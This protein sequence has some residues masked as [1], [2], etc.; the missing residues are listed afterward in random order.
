MIEE[1]TPS[2]YNTAS[3]DGNRGEYEHPARNAFLRYH[4][5]DDKY[6]F[7]ATVHSE[8]GYTGKFIYYKSDDY[9]DLKLV[10]EVGGINAIK[11][12]Q[13]QSKLEMI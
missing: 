10:I 13:R 3:R 6:Y 2:E 12:Q 7:W 5:L 11:L 9:S 4:N 8:N 1:I